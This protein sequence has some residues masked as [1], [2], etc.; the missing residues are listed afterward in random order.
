MNIKTII[1]K[2][3][4]QTHGKIL[5]KL[6]VNKVIYPERYTANKLIRAFSASGV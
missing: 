2:A 4:N 6:G 3:I 5:S 1:A